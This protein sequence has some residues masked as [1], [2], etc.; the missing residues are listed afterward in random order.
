MCKKSGLVYVKYFSSFT[1]YCLQCSERIH[2]KG[3][4]LEHRVSMQK[5]YNIT[6]LTKSQGAL[7][8]AK[9]KLK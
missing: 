2:R 4:L 5:Y 3:T 6:G 9:L 8:D 1:E 7:Q